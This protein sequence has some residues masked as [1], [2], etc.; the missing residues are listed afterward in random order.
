[1]KTL[2]YIPLL[3]L[4][5]AG[6]KSQDIPPRTSHIVR[7]ESQPEG[8][9]IYQGD[10]LLGTT[11]L[12][13]DGRFLGRMTAYYPGRN[14]WNATVRSL[15]ESAPSYLEG[16]LFLEFPDR[17]Y[18]RTVPSDAAV[19]RHGQLIGRTPLSISVDSDMDSLRISKPGYE[20]QYLGLQGL[21]SQQFNI[22]L[23]PL[24]N[25]EISEE[26]RSS[27][28]AFRLPAT[29]ILLAGSVGLTAGITAVLLKE[30][31]DRH[32]NLYSEQGKQ[33]SLDT[34][35]RYDLFS[36]IALAILELSIA[37]LLFELLNNS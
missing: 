29:R 36:G 9:E 34:S 32:Y 25:F 7:V 31:A 22:I 35:R 37:Y 6:L 33:S 26:V 24:P 17:Y 13:V 11:P 30:Q 8:A 20:Q 27:E 4:F 1:M 28:P 21:E 3:L 23:I 16:V 5:S 12:K 18:V 15:P 19:Y 14:I 2:I 10:T